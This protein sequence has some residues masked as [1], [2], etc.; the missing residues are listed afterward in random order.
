MV[1]WLRR[2]RVG[3]QLRQ[4]WTALAIIVVGAG[5]LVALGVDALRHG[6]IGSL[7]E[8]IG[9]P[10]CGVFLM[11]GGLLLLLK[12]ARLRACPRCGELMEREPPP[13]RG[14]AR[15][16]Q[17]C[18]KCGQRVVVARLARG[19]GRHALGGSVLEGMER[20]EHL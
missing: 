8:A 10:V 13:E 2:W 3:I 6:G 12:A 11:G 17:R 14:D 15:A 19:R 4:D 18:A 7:A 9:I 5:M 16:L 20:R 1:R